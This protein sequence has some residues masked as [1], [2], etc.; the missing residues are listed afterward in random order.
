MARVTVLE[1]DYKIAAYLAFRTAREFR[2]GTE[3]LDDASLSFPVMM[4]ITFACE[5]YMKAISIWQ[6]KSQEVAK[7]HLLC[8]LFQT[9]PTNMQ[10]ELIAKCDP[11]HWDEYMDDSSD[12]F[13]QW[14]YFYEKD[15]VMFGHIGWLYTLADELEQIC[16][17]NISIKEVLCDE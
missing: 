7:T 2:K 16:T 6:A 12:A 14:R 13:R 9:L 17:S 11:E 4:N 15:H 8:E 5:L 3:L 1:T 10:T